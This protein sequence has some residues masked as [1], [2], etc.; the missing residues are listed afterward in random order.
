MYRKGEDDGENDDDDDSNGI[1]DGDDN[2]KRRAKGG[3]GGRRGMKV[4]ICLLVA[5][6]CRPGDVPVR[7]RG[8]L[9]ERG[10]LSGCKTDG[11]CL[12]LEYYGPRKPGWLHGPKIGVAEYVAG[13]EKVSLCWAQGVN[14]DKITKGARNKWGGLGP[15]SSFTVSGSGASTTQ[16]GRRLQ[17]NCQERGM[18]GD[19]FGGHNPQH[20]VQRISGVSDEEDSL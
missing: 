7:L 5:R 19:G 6:L 18:G 11:K 1:F 14:I 2:E 17:E 20:L 9:K 15:S 13:Q 16:W 4:E 8:V 3:K 10:V 12:A